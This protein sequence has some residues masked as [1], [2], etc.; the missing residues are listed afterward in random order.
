MVVLS[1][2]VMLQSGDSIADYEIDTWP[3]EHSWILFPFFI[4][5]MVTFYKELTKVLT[6]ITM[7][8][9]DIKD[10]PR[11]WRFREYYIIKF[12]EL[13][14]AVYGAFGYLVMLALYAN[15]D[16]GGMLFTVLKMLA[17]KFILQ[18]DEGM[19]I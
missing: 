1:R 19:V 5:A 7:L 13:L 3:L 9:H 18:L 10:E 6:D 12:G 2:L 8:K 15:H 14:L 17:Y 11:S 16:Y 4:I